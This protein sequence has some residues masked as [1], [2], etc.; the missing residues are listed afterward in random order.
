M[1]NNNFYHVNSNLIKVRAYKTAPLLF[2]YPKLLAWMELKKKAAEIM[3]AL[4]NCSSFRGWH[5]PQFV[6]I[7]VR[8]NKKVEILD[9]GDENEMKLEGSRNC[10]V[11]NESLKYELNRQVTSSPNGSANEL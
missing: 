11:Y 8:R 4:L 7:S 9:N 6:R 2:C 1:L 5:R 10:H 3:C